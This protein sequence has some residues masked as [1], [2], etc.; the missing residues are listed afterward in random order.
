MR[1][2]NFY[3]VIAGV[4]T[5]WQEDGLIIRQTFPS[6][7]HP[8]CSTQLQEFRKN[9]VVTDP[10]SFQVSKEPTNTVTLGHVGSLILFVMQNEFTWCVSY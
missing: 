8:Y 2:M 6:S 7:L 3:D 5:N 10:P 4:M 9:P 1:S